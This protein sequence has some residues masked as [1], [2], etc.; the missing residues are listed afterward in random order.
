MKPAR[1]VPVESR[2][3]SKQAKYEG[4]I[5]KTKIIG[6][7]AAALAACA[8]GYDT[9]EIEAVRDYIVA[10]E[11]KEV[12][13]IRFFSQMSYTYLND[14]YVLIPTRRGDYLVE[15]RRNC[16][17]LR[18]TQFTWDMVDRRDNQNTL[19]AGFDTIR[20]C[21]IG[22]MYEITEDQRE[23]LQALGDAPGDEVFIPESE[24]T[25]DKQ[26]EDEETE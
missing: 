10:A 19:R 26:T 18:E 20:G 13:Q 14:R 16:R 9:Q 2:E 1:C 23:E 21:I 7:A 25:D 3:R 15:F 17:E 11:L 4:H 8:T 6:I 12:D 5:M 22:G 24:D